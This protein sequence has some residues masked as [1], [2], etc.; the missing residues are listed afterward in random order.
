MNDTS[1]IVSVITLGRK[2]RVAARNGLV[3]CRHFAVDAATLNTY[4]AFK[5]LL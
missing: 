2:R 1:K 5:I 4:I 3:E